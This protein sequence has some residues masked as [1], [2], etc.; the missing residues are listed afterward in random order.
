M[1][2]RCSVCKLL[3]ALSTGGHPIFSYPP[4]V[5]DDEMRRRFPPPSPN[6]IHILACQQAEDVTGCHV[7]HQNRH[8]LDKKKGKAEGGRKETRQGHVWQHGMSIARRHTTHDTHTHTPM[9]ECHQR[10]CVGLVA[11][12]QGGKSNMTSIQWRM[13]GRLATRWPT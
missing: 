6:P 1:T 2:S 4:K 9:S 7:S 8:V 11:N 10:R 3:C 13:C 5:C 12:C